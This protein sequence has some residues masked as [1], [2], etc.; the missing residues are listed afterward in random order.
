MLAVDSTV[1][2]TLD[3]HHRHGGWSLTPVGSVELNARLLADAAESFDA[4]PRV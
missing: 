2:G 3:E 4:M 1:I